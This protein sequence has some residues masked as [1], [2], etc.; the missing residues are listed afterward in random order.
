MI[1][2]DNDQRR[3]FLAMPRNEQLAMLY[4]MIAYNR[5]ELATDK[6]DHV[7][8]KDDIKFMKNELMGIGMRGKDDTLTTTEKFDKLMGRRRDWG[9]W[10]ID[11]VLPQIVTLIILAVLALT[12]GKDLM[13]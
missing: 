4:D 13:P 12:F 2:N 3:V 11:R 6:S 5:N 8:M 10:F 7:A 1:R 9:A